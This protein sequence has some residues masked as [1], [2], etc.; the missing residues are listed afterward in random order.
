MLKQRKASVQ[1]E[2]AVGKLAERSE[3]RFPTAAGDRSFNPRSNKT[4]KKPDRRRFHEISPNSRKSRRSAGR[5]A[6]SHSQGRDIVMDVA[7]TSFVGIDIAK[8]TLDVH[9]LPER[10]SLQHSNDSKGRRQ[11]REQL[12]PPGLC[13][14]VVEATGGYERALVAELIDA[15]Y[16]V[17]VINPRQARD[18]AKACGHLAKTD[19]IDA[20]VLARFGE[21]V[22]LRIQAKIPEKQLELQDLVARR[23]Q[24]VQLR[25]GE[26]NR[27]QQAIS[28][29][30]RK[31][32]QET[33]DLLTKQIRR[34]EK[35]IAAL[36]QS[37]D[38]WKQ[39]TQIVQ[40][41]PG[42]GS[43]VSASLVSDVPELGRLNRQQI[44]A[45]IG[46]APFNCDSGQFRGQ[47]TIRGGRISVR[48]SL[49]MAALSARRFN[50][51]IRAFADRLAALG[52]KPKVILTACMRKL[53][54]ILNTM[55]KNK[56]VWNPEI[57][58]I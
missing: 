43:Q 23:R 54:V 25:A 22:E 42:V 26:M 52:K 32:L 50:P 44:A 33:I 10:R 38:E 12:P 39:K 1:N 29:P 53:L 19:R 28:K 36:V 5:R 48:C 56:T 46:I 21:A 14:I 45:L 3:A 4:A 51:V 58:T 6:S 47:R 31:S 18:F 57:S 34:L 8:R 35:H 20:A 17:A 11:L 49:Y 7:F 27:Q 40:S 9:V 13:L 16:H 41:V 37:D 24:L 2:P 15:G 30:V 55:V